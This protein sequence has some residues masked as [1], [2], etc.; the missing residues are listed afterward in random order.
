MTSPVKRSSLVR[1]ILAQ[2][3]SKTKSLDK[4]FHSKWPILGVKD[5]S[6]QG[7]QGCVKRLK[8]T[9][10]SPAKRS[11]LVTLARVGS[12]EIINQVA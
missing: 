7:G 3:S 8:F 2:R 11:S 9:M 10:K 5:A 4:G 12:D 6:C 1:S